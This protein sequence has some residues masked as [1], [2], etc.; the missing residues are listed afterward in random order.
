VLSDQ[1]GRSWYLR[2]TWVALILVVS[3]AI[4]DAVLTPTPAPRQPDFIDVFLASRAVVIAIRIAIVFAAAFIVLSVIALV[5]QRRWLTRVG[6]VE[7]GT[8]TSL[9]ADNQRLDGELRIANQTIEDLRGQAAHTRQVVDK[10][11]DL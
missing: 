8:L 6:P 9:E 10:E 1:K 7:V 4:A 3:L 5:A 2:A 11:Q